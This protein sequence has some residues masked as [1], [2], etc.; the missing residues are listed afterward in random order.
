MKKSP[1]LVPFPKTVVTE[2]RPDPTFVGTVAF[3]VVAVAEV[4]SESVTLNLKKLSVGVVLKLVPVM[5]TAVPGTPIVGVNEV[6]VGDFKLPTTNDVLLVAVDADLVTL[7]GPV[8]A[9]VGT[10]VTSLV[11]VAET[12]VAAVPLNLTTFWLATALKPVP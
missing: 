12:T 1:L 6:M 7:I 4:G 11:V 5:E 8:V 10:F 9:A 3:R 2:I